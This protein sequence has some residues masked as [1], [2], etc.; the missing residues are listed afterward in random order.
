M[1][2][3][4]IMDNSAIGATLL[5]LDL[6]LRSREIYLFIYF[7]RELPRAGSR[8]GHKRSFVAHAEPTR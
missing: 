7:C 1:E 4:S 5:T 3:L 6:E 8:S 2:I